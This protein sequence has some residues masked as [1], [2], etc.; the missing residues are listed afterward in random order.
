MNS[1]F[2]IYPRL[3]Q[4]DELATRHRTNLQFLAQLDARLP[5]RRRS[6]AGLWRRGVA[7]HAPVIPS[8]D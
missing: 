7:V 6:I 3:T 8:A 1:P 4:F 5:R 2:K